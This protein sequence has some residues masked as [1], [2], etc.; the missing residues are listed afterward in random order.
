MDTPAVPKDWTQLKIDAP[1]EG[2]VRIG[3][4][5]ECWVGDDEPNPPAQ[6][7]AGIC[8]KVD[9]N[10]RIS[11]AV[12]PPR[13]MAAMPIDGAIPHDDP[14][15]KGKYPSVYRYRHARF[16]LLTKWVDKLLKEFNDLRAEFDAFK[17]KVTSKAA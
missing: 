4:V 16:A 6:P 9:F 2:D 11:I 13:I 14:E 17:K 7:Y 8:T 12:F 10:G 5:V 15:A 3:D 1:R